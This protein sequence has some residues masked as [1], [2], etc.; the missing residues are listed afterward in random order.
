[1][2]ILEKGV[3]GTT[4]SSDIYITVEPNDQTAITIDLQSDVEKQYGDRIREVITNTAKNLGVESVKVTA[5][6]SGA[7]DC[8]ITA[9]T[10]NALQRALGNEQYDWK[11]IHSWNV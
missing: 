5:V 2:E 3:S 9:R 11:E 4:E 1:M 7:L 6:D 10:L 8:T